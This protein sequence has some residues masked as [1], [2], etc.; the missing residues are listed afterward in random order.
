MTGTEIDAA[1][2]KYFDGL[3][4]KED[5]GKWHL[6]R[7][8]ERHP[9][10]EWASE[11]EARRI[12]LSLIPEYHA[13]IEAALYLCLRVAAERDWALDFAIPVRGNCEKPQVSFSHKGTLSPSNRRIFFVGHGGE[14][15]IALRL[16]KLAL[17]VKEK[18][19]KDERRK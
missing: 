14:D 18:D 13:S 9:Q 11:E 7:F 3:E 16:A 10:W 5:N 15:P 12:F 4:I 17:K 2:A 8:G 6:Y 1:L 19:E